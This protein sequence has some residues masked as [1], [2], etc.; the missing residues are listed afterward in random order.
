M[1]LTNTLQPR[2]GGGRGK[3][4]DAVSLLLKLYYCC[5]IE[6]SYK[7][8]FAKTNNSLDQLGEIGFIVSGSAKL[9]KYTLFSH[10][11]VELVFN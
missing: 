6:C 11:Y 9:L 1:S 8:M 5:V 2:S 4:I 7:I 10:P 3:V